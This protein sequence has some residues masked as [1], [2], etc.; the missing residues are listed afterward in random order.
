MV[1]SVLRWGHNCCNPPPCLAQCLV[2][3][4]CSRDVNVT[5]IP[6][7]MV[8]P[9]PLLH[10]LGRVAWKQWE[11][12]L[13]LVSPAQHSL[14]LRTPPD[15]EPHAYSHLLADEWEPSSCSFR[16]VWWAKWMGLNPQQQASPQCLFLFFLCVCV[17]FQGHT[18]GIWKF[19]G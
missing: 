7:C 15:G 2:H 18:C 17:L 10:G 11:L 6:F 8:A 1:G 3:R 9:S 5:V 12:C 14:A 4:K 16:V 13:R 19:P